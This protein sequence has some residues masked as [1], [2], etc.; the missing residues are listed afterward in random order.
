[1]GAIIF[2][3]FAG[4][5][6]FLIVRVAKAHDYHRA[7]YYVQGGRS[8]RWISQWTC[9][10]CLTVNRCPRRGSGFKCRNKAC[11]GD[12][13]ESVSHW[14]A[15]E[16]KGIPYTGPVDYVPY[17][18]RDPEDAERQYHWRR[19]LLTYKAQGLTY[20]QALMEKHKVQP[21]H[22]GEYGSGK[23]FD[24]IPDNLPW[25]KGWKS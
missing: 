12:R 20:K 13:D 23:T 25:P 17:P 2:W 18:R 6:A 4:V 1:M 16:K 9:K 11:K 5:V 19:A 8:H 14:V 7:G 15:C 3:L 24:D 22:I 21:F 10:D